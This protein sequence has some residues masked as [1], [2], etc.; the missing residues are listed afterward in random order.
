MPTLREF[1][2]KNYAEIQRKIYPAYIQV[3]LGY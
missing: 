3:T 2:D 1:L